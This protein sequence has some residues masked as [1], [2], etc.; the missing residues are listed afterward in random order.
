MVAPKEQAVD[1]PNVATRSDEESWLRLRDFYLP[2]R[3]YNKSLDFIGSLLFL[4]HW[5]HCLFMQHSGFCFQSGE[6]SMTQKIL[7]TETTFLS[8]N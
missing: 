4:E 1:V 6:K 7:T 2:G 8:K 5:G 3:D